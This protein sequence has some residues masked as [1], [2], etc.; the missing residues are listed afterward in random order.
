M[1]DQ[2]SLFVA[3]LTCRISR[4]SIRNLWL[5]VR[6]PDG[7]V[8]IS[9][10]F[11]LSNA[12]IEQ[13]VLARL[14]WIRER[15]AAIAA[16]PALTDGPGCQYLW[17]EKHEVIYRRG[18]AGVH[19][20]HGRIVLSAPHP[21]DA[22]K[23]GMMLDGFLRDQ[24]KIHASQPMQYWQKRLGLSGITMHP[25]LMRRRWGTCY[26]RG[27]KIILNSRLAA[28]P[29]IC[30]AFVITHELLHFEIPNHG[31]EFKKLLAALWPRHRQLDAMLDRS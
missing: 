2:S 22:A 9:A 23:A 16:M 10:P 18:P 24:V 13:F 5:R 21:P 19:A 14:D 12:R 17:G 20:A 31:P 6:Q 7:Q 4:K 15:Q 27:R 11:Q 28:K 30:L 25:R 1:S 26:P 29:R 8:L 3:G